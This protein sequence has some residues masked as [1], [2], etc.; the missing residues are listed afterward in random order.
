ML[1]RVFHREHPAPRLADD[2]MPVVDAEVPCQ[3]D[4]LVLEELRRPE[5]GR[6]VGQV[7][8][9]AATELVV[10]DA[11]AAVP[12][13]VGDRLDVVVRRAGTAVADDDGRLGRLARRRR[14]TTSR[15]RAS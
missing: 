4:E 14:G 9:P 1:E 12:A 15:A 13:Q 8:A 11:R 2:G 6:R 10:E 5:L 7:L 3:R